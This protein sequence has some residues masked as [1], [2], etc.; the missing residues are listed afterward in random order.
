MVI[1]F[2]NY[3]N[4]L[5]FGLTSQDVNTMAYSNK[6]LDFKR[7]VFIP[8]LKQSNGI[9]NKTNRSKHTVI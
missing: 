5:H 9:C 1:G 6:I 8:L 4:L 3:L 2:D 7:D